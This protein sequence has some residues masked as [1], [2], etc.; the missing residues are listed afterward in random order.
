M[1][2]F[3]RAASFKGGV[4]L[5]GKKH[6]SRDSAIEAPP[7][8]AYVIIPLWQHAG[9][10]AT[11]CVETGQRVKTGERIGTPGSA[12][13]APVHASISG[14]VTEIRDIDLP[15]GKKSRAIVIENDGRDERAFLAPIAAWE[16]AAVKDL[17]A[18]IDDAGIV[19][20]GG[21]A[22][23]AKV[24]L[25]LPPGKKADILLING[26]ECEPYLTADY[27]LMIERAP[28]VIT[29]IRILLRV[30]GIG[31]AIIGVE[32]HNAPGIQALEKAIGSDKTISLRSLKV[33]YPQGAEKILIK[34]MLGREV[35][36]GGL[37]IDAG[38]IV[39]NIG[40]AEA[41]CKAVVLGQP[42]IER[43]VTVSGEAIAHPKNLLARIGTPIGRLIEQC[44]GITQEKVTLI[45]GGP[46]MGLPLESLDLP[47]TKGLCGVLALPQRTMPDPKEIVCINCGRCF[48][49]CPL[50]L[51]P[52]ELS[53]LGDHGLIDEAVRQGVTDCCHCGLCTVMCPGGRKNTEIIKR[54]KETALQR[55]KP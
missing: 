20:L 23:P 7:L 4:T 40:T 25:S 55:K 27:R 18:R 54:L 43:V 5:P 14:A 26:A 39:H 1:D 19:G 44:G 38:A 8:P 3:N 53:E 34:T 15:G 37:P 35:P 12:V 28:E 42:L 2:L 16:N 49:G 21:A 36:S 45:A 46:M 9:S 31:R 6:L 10:S 47:V 41:V 24:K 13:S 51:N 48:T 22:F 11:A 29:G 50:G 52:S 17:L 33:K 32:R 30:L